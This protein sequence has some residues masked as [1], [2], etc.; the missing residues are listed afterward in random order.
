M[1][2][3]FIPT[4]HPV[5]RLA[6]GAGGVWR[7]GNGVGRRQWSRREE[8]IRNEK[9][10]LFRYCW[11]PPIWRVVDALCG[12]PW[13]DPVWAARMRKHLRF[14][15]PVAACLTLGGNRASK[16]QK[17]AYTVMR[18]L[19]TTP[20]A[21]AWALHSNLQ[22]SRDYQQPLFYHYLPPELKV[23]DIKEKDTYIAYKQK[24]GFSDE[25]FVLPPMRAGYS[26]Q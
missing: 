4:R 12:F 13:V 11:Q 16:S 1:S 8:I 17:N 14:E 18:V 26:R 25:K 22:M 21:R 20:A 9:A 23:K 7:W 10:D 3:P 5:L 24:T 6:F 15:N 19:R 2:K